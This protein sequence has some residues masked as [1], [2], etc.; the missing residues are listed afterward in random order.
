MKRLVAWLLVLGI[1]VVAA[2]MRADDEKKDK[3]KTEE[4]KKDDKKDEK[5]DDK[6]DEKKDEK[7]DSD[8]PKELTEAQKK[9]LERLSG[10]FTVTTFERDGKQA[11]PDQLKKM[12]VIQKGADWSFHDGDDI[13]TGKDT[14][15]PDKTPREINSTYTN[16]PAKDQTVQGIYEISNDTIKYCWA[17]TGKDRPK[18]FATK[19]DSGLTLMI[20]QRVKAD[21]EFEKDKEKAKDKDKEEKKE[22]DKDKEEK[23]EDKKEKD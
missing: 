14:V 19:P 17:T 1:V 9:E 15:F 21:K 16:G 13:T 12:K 7:K 20:L 11:T 10:T 18:E 6:K 23:K 3:D 8:K 2:P 22:K 4:K 5:K